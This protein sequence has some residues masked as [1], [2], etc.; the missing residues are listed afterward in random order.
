MGGPVRATDDRRSGRAFGPTCIG[1]TV[2]F[3]LLGC[4]DYGPPKNTE[5]LQNLQPVTGSVSFGGE[6][7]PGAVVFFFP[8]ADLEAPDRR[9]AGIVEVDGTFEM[10]STV[11]AGSRPGVEPGEYLVS[12]SWTEL[13]N[14]SD[15]DSDE[16]PDKLPERYKDP[17]TSGLRAEIVEGTN[18]LPPFELTP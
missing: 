9:I 17:K 1:L 10:K 8:V 12:V 2:A 4:S 16:G 13:V 7:T 5:G 6:P 11:G 14:P 15:R 3:C 18:E